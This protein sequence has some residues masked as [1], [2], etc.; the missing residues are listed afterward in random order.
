[1]PFGGLLHGPDP[2]GDLRLLAHQPVR[3]GLVE[4]L[5]R[6]GLGQLGVEPFLQVGGERLLLVQRRLEIAE[7]FGGLVLAGL[8]SRLGFGPVGLLDLHVLVRLVQLVEEVGV[9]VGLDLDQRLLDRGVGQRVGT[10]RVEGIVGGRVDE[11]L[12]HQLVGPAVE[13]VDPPLGVRDR[14]DGG[15][16]VGLGRLVRPL[17]LV[18]L[19]LLGGHV[20]L[21]LG[22]CRLD[23]G[24]LGLEGV[25][26]QVDLRVLRSDGIALPL[27]LGRVGIV[28]PA[29]HRRP[30]G[31]QGRQG[32][33]G[34]D[35]RGAA[36]C[37]S[38]GSSLL[39]AAL[40]ASG[41]SGRE[42][43]EPRLRCQPCGSYATRL[44]R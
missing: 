42:C 10:E 29:R 37:G 28:G 36:E 19:G 7:L 12:D 25:D 13:V 44:P 3:Q 35:R 17:G 43:N 1:L 31:H 41:Q 5:Q 34:D 15:R 6:L 14:L 8:R 32:D 39:L 18:Q 9:G 23:L 21:E 26:L 40:P 38:H 30:D 4:H 16:Q 33:H 22:Q 24:I 27:G 11:R 2:A 20:G